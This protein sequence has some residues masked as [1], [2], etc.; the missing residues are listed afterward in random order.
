MP[1]MFLKKRETEVDMKQLKCEFKEGM[2]LEAI[3]PQFLSSIRV[4]SVSRVL[5]NKNYLMIR[6]DGFENQ[7]GSDTFCYHRTSANILPAGFC[8]RHKIELSAPFSYKGRFDWTSYL[9][10]TNSEF[11]PANLFLNVRNLFIC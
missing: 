6:F 1:S 8:N 3:D 11:A 7:D 9:S 4:A 10:K 5:E 2:R